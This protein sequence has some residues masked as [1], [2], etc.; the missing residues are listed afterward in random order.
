MAR[1]K[2]VEAAW[3]QGLPV[4]A[5][6]LNLAEGEHPSHA[7][8]FTSLHALE[9]VNP[10]HAMFALELPLMPHANG[11]HMVTDA[12]ILSTVGQEDT[13][14]LA[15]VFVRDLAGRVI[16]TGLNPL[17]VPPPQPLMPESCREIPLE[18]PGYDLLDATFFTTFRRLEWA[19]GEGRALTGRPEISLHAVYPAPQL[20]PYKLR[21]DSFYQ[22]GFRLPLVERLYVRPADPD[23][24]HVEGES[25]LTRWESRPEG[26]TYQQFHEA[27][28]GETWFESMFAKGCTVIPTFEAT[29][30]SFVVTEDY[31]IADAHAGCVVEGL[32]DVLDYRASDKPAGTILDVVCPGYA[33][34][35]KVVPAKVVASDGS[36]Y[37]SP[38]GEVPEPLQPNPAWP[39]PRVADVNDVWLPTHPG[40]FELPA[41]W[42]WNAQGHFQQVAGPL[43][44]PVHYTYTSTPRI[45]KAFRSTEADTPDLAPV[46]EDMRPRFHPVCALT[47]YDT[48]NTTTHE[49]RAGR[50]AACPFHMSALDAVPMG[51]E[52]ADIGYHPLPAPWE[53]E[54]DPAAFPHLGPRH[55]TETVPENVTPVITSRVTAEDAM[56]LA[57]LNPEPVRKALLVEKYFQG[58]YG[59]ERYTAEAL[60]EGPVGLCHLPDIST[61][62]LM[63]NVK[64]FFASKAYVA[65][66]EDLHPALYTQFFLFREMALAARRLRHRLARKYPGWYL[67]MWWFGHTPTRA[68]EALHD[69]PELSLRAS[70]GNQQYQRLQRCHYAHGDEQRFTMGRLEQRYRCVTIS[71]NAKRI[72]NE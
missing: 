33:T 50:V 48:F 6:R 18:T 28:N 64:R 20:Y 65:G 31:G 58:D 41:L 71:N 8:S 60:P 24:A 52:V 44:D 54:L 29:N 30:G 21:V 27:N 26:Q 35:E 47:T 40:H 23:T 59:L 72:G 32:H 67:W 16:H 2:Q 56:K 12:G 70:D 61:S 69:N 4:A 19:Y 13:W 22:D 43:W 51:H 25:L 36:G 10:P 53:Y 34:R 62:E 63:I 9:V 42:D 37:V 5:L 17:P 49:F 46:P 15:P 38:L 45:L 1:R 11:H 39:H 7:T 55:R 14:P 66:L 68:E 3:P 57:V